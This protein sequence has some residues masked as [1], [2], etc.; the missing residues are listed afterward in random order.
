MDIILY[1]M[2][3][4][5]S[6]SHFSKQRLFISLQRRPLNCKNYLHLTVVSF[7][8]QGFTGT[9]SSSF[10]SYLFFLI[11]YIEEIVQFFKLV[12]SFR[13]FSL[14]LLISIRLLLH[15]NPLVFFMAADLC[16]YSP[17][18]FRDIFR[19]RLRYCYFSVV[20]LLLNLLFEFLQLPIFLL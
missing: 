9:S 14:L 13:W 2:K 4:M 17:L 11:L 1:Q 19:F 15:S 8:S 10:R 5:T 18:C 3:G 20:C 12:S 7:H 6:S 16:V